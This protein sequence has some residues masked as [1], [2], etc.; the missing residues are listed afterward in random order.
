[1]KNSRQLLLWTTALVFTASLSAEEAPVPSVMPELQQELAPVSA[2]PET[3]PEPVVPEAAESDEPTALPLDELRKFA[4][5]FGTI[6]NEYVEEIDDVTLLNHAIQGMLSGLDPH[7][8][9]L[10]PSDYND[11]KETTTGSFGGLGIEVGME[12]GFVKVIA[13]IDDTPAEKSGIQAG[14]LIIRLDET[15]VKGMSLSEAVNVMR[16][17][18]GTS[19]TLTI[20]REGA[21]EPLVIEVMRAEIK[22]TSVKTIPLEKHY[23]YLRITQFQKQT[24]TDFINGI[25]T[26]EDNL[27]QLRGLIIDLR[28]NP[29]GVLQAAVEVADQLL[30]EGLIVYTQGRSE[31]SRL[32]MNATPGDLLQGKPVIV[33][34]D[35][36]S[37]SAS[38]ILAGA[39]QDHKRAVIMGVQSFGKGSVQNVLPLGQDYGLK[40]TTARYY[41]PSGRSIQAQGIT[42]D[43][44]V[45]RAR[46]GDEKEGAGIREAD[47]AGH[48]SNDT[49]RSRMSDSEKAKADES[50]EQARIRANLER[51][52]QLQEALNLLK[53][54][55]ILNISRHD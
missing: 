35:G 28:N 50:D 49:A 10:E 37:A 53:A 3:A 8:A 5:V 47:L 23:G 46:L 9:Y 15:P 54:I 16:G 17:D 14:D 51:D 1:M 2:P 21:R 20:V 52:F 44:E 11:L 6:K 43:I 4:N 41:T 25:R 40:L 29:G 32:S 19:I 33:L 42:P 45:K 31:L 22:V 36:G 34:V 30:E 39:L 38:E 55:D 26:L 7:S 48:L 27:E 18:P 13:P 12:N 24:G